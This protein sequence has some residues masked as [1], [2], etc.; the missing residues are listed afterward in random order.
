MDKVEENKVPSQ[1]NSCQI[2]QIG[3]FSAR[4]AIGLNLTASCTAMNINVSLL[5]IPQTR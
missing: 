2:S 1:R 4:T 3:N 5:A